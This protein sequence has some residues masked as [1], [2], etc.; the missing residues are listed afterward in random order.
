MSRYHNSCRTGCGRWVQ[1]GGLCRSCARE[2]NMHIPTAQENE[3]E[4]SLAAQ[5]QLDKL[6]RPIILRSPK[7]FTQGDDLY[8]ITFDGSRPDTW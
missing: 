2:A 7:Y 4:H 8:E 3:R 5:A 1:E 6:R